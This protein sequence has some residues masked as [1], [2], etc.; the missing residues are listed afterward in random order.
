[1]RPSGRNPDQLRTIKLTR[2]YIKH[3]EGAVLVEF[4]DTRVLCTATVEE[5]VRFWPFTGRPHPCSP[6][7]RVIAERLAGDAALASLFHFNQPVITAKGNRYTVDILWAEGAMIVEIDGHH[8]HSSRYAF[9]AD[10]Q[11]DYELLV[12]GYLVL[13]LAHDEVVSDPNLALEKIRDVVHFRRSGMTKG[14]PT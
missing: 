3:P 13:R 12:S 5:K 9:A 2:N 4:G 10:R 14:E 8:Y 11:R 1:M 7:E 6:G